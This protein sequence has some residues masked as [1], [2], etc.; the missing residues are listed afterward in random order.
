MENN[1]QITVI[2]ATLNLYHNTPLGDPTVKRRVAVYARVSTDKDEQETSFEAQVDFYTKYIAERDDWIMSG[3][4]TDEG[5][6]GLNTK[7][8]E[9][10]K[11][12]VMDGLAGKFDLLITKSISRFARNTVDSLNTIRTFK[13][14]GVECYFEKEQIWTFDG[15][16]ELL[17]TIMSSIA[18]EESRN[19]S[20]NVTWGARK[21]FADGKVSMP[22]RQFLGYE[23]GKDGTP[24]IVES[25]AKIVR[26][27]YQMYLN[28]STI[29]QIC[30]TLTGRGIPTPSSKTV[31]A[32]S[33]IKSIL[34]NERYKGDALLQKTFCA[35]YLTKKMVKNEGQV[36]QYYVENSHPGIVT[37]E[38]FDLVQAEI[39]R[40]GGFGSGR[41]NISCFSGKIFCPDCGSVYGRRTW[42]TTENG[43]KASRQVWQCGGKYKERGTTCPS[44]NILEEELRLAFILAFNQVVTERERYI[45][46]LE[47]I[48]DLLADTTAFDNEETMLKERAAGIY[49]QI[50]DLVND[51][52]R[53]LRDQAEYTRQY[54]ELTGRYNSFK[55]RLATLEHERQCQQT[56]RHGMMK[57]IQAVRER[58]NL[59]ECFDEPLFRATVESI[60]IHAKNDVAVKF[61]DGQKIHV[62]SRL[63][64]YYDAE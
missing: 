56:K 64:K 16:G 38:V 4:Y 1:P 14:K 6:S 61:R 13:E 11:Q 39:E 48:L 52:A 51:N 30:N 12:M 22:Y 10:F 34:T 44:V 19:I 41:S 2:P 36:E 27:I 35:D 57:F 25:E 60:T 63:K 58:K 8:R 59:L 17:V 46:A 54:T 7:K 50:S 9:G 43:K 47:P 15:K 18:Q 24:K 3:I 49:A 45:T 20:Q 31:W 37:A 5:I 28:G 42:R 32:V 62:D 33:T 21:R 53:T 29:R 26:E 23:K 55:E 40:N